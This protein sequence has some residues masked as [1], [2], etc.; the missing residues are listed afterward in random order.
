MMADE[1]ITTTGIA[2][3]GQRFGDKLRPSPPDTPS[4]DFSEFINA[5]CRRCFSISASA[6]NLFAPSE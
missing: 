1:K 6:W 2:A 4:E 3:H 5:G